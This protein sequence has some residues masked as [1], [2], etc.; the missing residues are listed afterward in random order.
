[1]NRPLSVH[2][3][4]DVRLLCPSGRKP[5][6]SIDSRLIHLTHVAFERAISRPGIVVLDLEA[7]WCGPCRTFGPVFEQAAGRHGDITFA[8]VNTDAER[9]LARDWRIES[10]PTVMAFKDGMAAF[11]Q[12][13][14]LPANSLDDLVRQLR[15]LDM[16]AVR[17]QLSREAPARSEV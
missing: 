8:K 16:R 17:Q 11:S 6:T 1:M 4:I 3:G 14:V 2:E 10:I 5:A 13:G 12:A 15:A 7:P 9:A